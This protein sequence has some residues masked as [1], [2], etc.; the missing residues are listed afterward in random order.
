MRG[1]VRP[2]YRCDDCRKARAADLVTRL[3]VECLGHSLACLVTLTY[4]DAFLPAGRSLSRADARAFLKRFRRAAEYHGGGSGLR[5]FLVGEYGTQ[6]GRPHYHLIIWGA[7]AST[8]WGGRSLPEL[9][10]DCWGKGSIDVGKYW[11]AKAASYVSGYVV[12][13]LNIKGL[14]VLGDR[15]PE[16]TIF[17]RPALGAAGLSQL[18]ELV[19]GDDDPLAVIEVEG[20]LPQR[21]AL[22]SNGGDERLLRGV[23]LDKLRLHAGV[24]PHRLGALKER[25]QLLALGVPVS[26]DEI[27][28][29]R[30]ERS[31][32]NLLWERIDDDD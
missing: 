3:L 13:G 24:E 12:K 22:G 14:S 31:I 20:D 26:I 21:V 9:V 15:I 5:I 1:A 30:A 18:L 7:D 11:S 6:S 25:K 19:V 10:K 17:P 16:F 32:F 8:A 23:L 29:L 28:R 4:A 27:A 2:C